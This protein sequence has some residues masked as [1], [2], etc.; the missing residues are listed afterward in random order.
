MQ[1]IIPE[2]VLYEESH[3][4]TY[5]SQE[6]SC[7]G[8][9]VD[10]KVGDDIGTLIVLAH[11]I[12]RRREERQQDLVFRMFATQLF[13]KRPA[14]FELSERGCVKPH[15]LCLRV[16]FLLEDAEC[17]ALTTPHLTHF[18]VEATVDR[19]TKQVKI[20]EDVIHY[21]STSMARRIRVIV[22]SLP[23]NDEISNI[24]GPLPSPTRVRRQAFIT[25]P[26]LYSFCSTH[27]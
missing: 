27:A 6:S 24:P 15:V 5:K 23:R 12:T 13:H 26:S 20:Y 16:N 22:S 17:L 25:L 10:G 21:P 14:L 1:V 19:H 11:L 2:L 8:N 7:V 18:L 4:R 9:G 3:H